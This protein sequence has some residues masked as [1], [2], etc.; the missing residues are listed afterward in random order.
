MVEKKY[1][2]RLQIK[3]P[4][5]ELTF[6][7]HA[8]NLQ[9]HYDQKLLQENLPP[10]SGVIHSDKVLAGS[11][12]RVLPESTKDALNQTEFI[13]VFGRIITQQAHPDN[14]CLQ[15]LYVWD[16]QAVPTHEADY[17]PIFVFLNG[18]ERYAL[19]DL[20]HYCSRRLN[21]G[22]VS[23][24]GPGLRMVP[25]WHSFLPVSSLQRS[26]LDSDLNV[27]P[28]SDKHLHS[29][30]TI[31]DKAPRLKINEYMLNPFVLE[32]PGHFLISPDE[33]SRTICC[34][35][36]EIET[37]IREFDDPRTGL[38][39]GIKRALTR[40]IGLFALHRLGALVTLLDEMNEVG[41]VNLGGHF[42][43][44]FNL[45]AITH[46]LRDGFLTLTQS[47]QSFFEGLRKNKD[48][49]N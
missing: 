18:D 32:S 35:F 3:V 48:D 41:L 11:L 19:Y 22:P 15:Y 17:E 44:G 38:T 47:G 26:S 8:D 7:E 39:E 49:T 10:T 9:S 16:Y 28:L 13:G 14:L 4:Y 45:G 31:P 5:D 27:Q 33:E 34:V 21:L 36:S 30:W 29:W 40:C 46:M 42:K 24:D 25:G 1:Q 2:D 43:S 37:A 23:K 20:V 6:T 12:D